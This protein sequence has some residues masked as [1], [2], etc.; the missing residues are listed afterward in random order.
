MAMTL[1]QQLKADKL[2]ARKQKHEMASFMVTLYAEALAVG[3]NKRNGESTDE[4][5]ISV[6]KR[7]KAGAETI[8]QAALMKPTKP[9]RLHLINQAKIEIFVV[10]QYLP[11]MM[12]ESELRL[13]LWQYINK[14]PDTYSSVGSIM[15]ELK[16]AYPGKYDGALASKLI[17]EL[18]P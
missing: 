8:I 5:V 2:L 9:I 7:F 10:E 14:F 12:T 6:L 3:K 1:L 11:D 17:R 15:S 13:A 18:L 16:K 4:E